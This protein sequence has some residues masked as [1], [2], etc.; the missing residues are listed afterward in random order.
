T[1]REQMNET[2]QLSVITGESAAKLKSVNLKLVEEEIGRFLEFVEV[3]E[4][5]YEDSLRLPFQEVVAEM[6]EVS[7]LILEATSDAEKLQRSLPY[8]STALDNINDISDRTNILS[9][10]ASIEAARAGTYGRGFAVVAEEIGRLAENSVIGSQ[11]VRKNILNMINLFK[12]YE[13]KTKNAISKM[14]M[15]IERLSNIKSATETNSEMN[16]PKL[17]SEVK[18]EVEANSA[19][20]EII[21]NEMDHIEN[22]ADKSKNYAVE[23]KNKISE[24]I[25]NIESIAGISD[26]IKDLIAHLNDTISTITE[27]SKVLEELTSTP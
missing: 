15:L 6:G 17:S 25:I 18:N 7:R 5:S 12:V 1:V 24:H 23:M 9:L 8:V 27:Q 22:I 11:D 21:V 20:V 3:M 2:D 26:S 4:K 19:V 14:N 10:N 13:E 16:F